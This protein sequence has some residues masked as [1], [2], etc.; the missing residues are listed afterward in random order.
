MMTITV[1]L[2][3]TV[4]LEC[5]TFFNLYIVPIAAHQCMPDP[6]PANTTADTSV[7]HHE[8]AHAARNTKNKKSAMVLAATAM[9]AEPIT[10]GRS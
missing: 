9:M 8:F 2:V 6:A 5:D 10:L 4:L 1:T 7:F 3:E